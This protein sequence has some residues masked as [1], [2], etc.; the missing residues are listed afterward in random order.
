MHRL[1]ILLLLAGPAFAGEAQDPE[2]GGSRCPSTA[3][4]EGSEPGSTV[5]LRPAA[6]PALQPAGTPSAPGTLPERA[7]PRLKAPAWQSYLPGMFK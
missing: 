7:K 6:P 2:G 3:A 1:L 5:D 4:A